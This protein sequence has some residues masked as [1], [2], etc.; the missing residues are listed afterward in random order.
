MSQF[1]NNAVFWVE[2][3]RIDPNPFQPRKDF[4]EQELQSLA[5]SIRQYGVLQ[6]LVVTRREEEKDD[7]GLQTRYELISGERRLRA[8]KL[9]GVREVPVLIRSGEEN[10][11]MK[12]EL[13]II[14]NIQREDLNVIDRAR[15]FKRLVD[16]FGFS[17]GQVAKRVGKSREYVSNS[18]RVLSLP[19]HMVEALS[20][21]KLSEGHG[22]P[23]GTLAD[24]PEQQETLFKEILYK[25]LS[26]REAER[27]ARRVAY[28]RVRKKAHMPEPE[29]VE[30]EEKLS[31]T[32]GT[33]VQV[34]RK[35]KGGRISIDFFSDDDLETIMTRV[36]AG[37]SGAKKHDPN[38]MLYRHIQQT[39][40]AEA[41]ADPAKASQEESTHEELSQK[42]SGAQEQTV[43][44]AMEALAREREQKKQEREAKR[45]SRNVE[46]E[47]QTEDEASNGSDTV[48]E[49]PQENPAD[50][51]EQSPTE[52]VQPDSL[53]KDK[54]HN[55]DGQKKSAPEEDDSLY[56]VRNFTI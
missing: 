47:A 31:E 19:E 56:S 40:H 22:R 34:E 14:E 46:V 29:L 37:E 13:A 33:R 21:G 20:Q 42:T 32:F 3:D 1:Y 2:V 51:I 17:H 48:P 25:K 44:D 23:L 11:K 18:L 6:A 45:E 54:A 16:E 24:R 4:N 30:I 49:D 39:K 43:T 12:L 55:A 7:G 28:D 35:E 15:A 41:E 9:A 52:E 27:I 36:R 26:V 38:E 50:N 8:S 10:S 5:D 53:T